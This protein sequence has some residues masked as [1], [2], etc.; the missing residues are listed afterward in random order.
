MVTKINKI[1]TDMNMVIMETGQKLTGVGI[2][3]GRV[4]EN[5]KKAGGELKEAV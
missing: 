4:N 2:A 5:L 1:T 3:M